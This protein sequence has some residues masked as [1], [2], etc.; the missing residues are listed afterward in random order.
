MTFWVMHFTD[1]RSI[2][3]FSQCGLD[4]YQRRMLLYITVDFSNIQY[5]TYLTDKMLPPQPRPP[6]KKK[7]L[8]KKNG[9]LLYTGSALFRE[10]NRFEWNKFFRSILYVTKVNLYF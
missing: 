2:I 6:P 7:K 8:I 9:F 4:G 5:T 10:E 3:C 1:A